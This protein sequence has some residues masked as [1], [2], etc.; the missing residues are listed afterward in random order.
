MEIK[1]ELTPPV[2]R[3]LEKTFPDSLTVQYLL[4][5]GA[6]TSLLTDDPGNPSFLIATGPPPG[7]TPGELWDTAGGGGG[8]PT[9]ANLLNAVPGNLVDAILRAW[10][11]TTDPR[12]DGFLLFHMTLAEWDLSPVPLCDGAR[13]RRLTPADAWLVNKHWVRGAGE[14]T[15]EYVAE[16]LAT[17]GG[18]GVETSTGEL[19]SYENESVGMAYTLEQHR[20]RGYSK[21]AEREVLRQ[22][23]AAGVGTAY[24]YTHSRNTSVLAYMAA[25]GY[26]A[27]E[28]LRY[29]VAIK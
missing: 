22:Q 10:P 13:V 11:D 26:S 16:L 24:L 19:V 4:R 1:P 25:E 15:L 14:G 29:L 17:Y 2:L 18:A 27:A 7:N 6:V 8:T 3:L 28:G 21:A 5:N 12:P 9:F 23:K 20:G